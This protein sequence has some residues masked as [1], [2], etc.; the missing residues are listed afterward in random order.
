MITL[1]ITRADDYEGVYLPLPTTPAEIGEAWVELDTIS[2]FLQEG[3]PQSCKDFSPA[4]GWGI[5]SPLSA[6]QG[7]SHPV[8]RAVE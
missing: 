5:L 2:C 7:V 4:G 1:H 3:N 8:A 6:H